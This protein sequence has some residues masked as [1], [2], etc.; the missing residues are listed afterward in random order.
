MR[1]LNIIE[2]NILINQYRLK[3]MLT[4]GKENLFEIRKAIYVL[5]HGIEDV[6]G[7][8]LSEPENQYEVTKKD[9]RMAWNI[10][11][12]SRCVSKIC[13]EMK[14]YIPKT[15]INNPTGLGC[16]LN[17]F[18]IEGSV[19]ECFDFKGGT[20]DDSDLIEFSRK[21]EAIMMTRRNNKQ[22]ITRKDVLDMLGIDE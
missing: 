10:I 22:H 12:A 4:K 11:L 6:V 19:D 13:P 5:K 14:K 9:F 21:Y 1:K 16:A 7:L 8:E 15:N 18:T 3:E 17:L 2:R 20:K